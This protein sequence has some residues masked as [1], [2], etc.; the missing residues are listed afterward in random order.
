MQY[1]DLSVKKSYIELRMHYEDS[2]SLRQA[3]GSVRTVQTITCECIL[4]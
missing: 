3:L 1:N 4:Y 2:L